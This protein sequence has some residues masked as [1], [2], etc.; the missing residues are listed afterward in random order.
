MRPTP[1]LLNAAK[2]SS[3]FNLPVELTPLFAAVGVAIASA[4]FFT[5]RHFAHDKELRLWKNPD[6]STLDE[7]L[8]KNTKK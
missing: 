2:K 4:G 1:A 6:L 5:Y 8:D 7:V 3:G